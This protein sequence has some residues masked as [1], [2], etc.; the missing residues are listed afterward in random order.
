[1]IDIELQEEP[2]R[3]LESVCRKKGEEYRNAEPFPHA[4]LDDIVSDELLE[5]VDEEFPSPDSGQ[6]QLLEKPKKSKNK[7]ITGPREDVGPYTRYLFGELGSP[8]FLGFLE[9]LTGIRKLISDPYLHGGG[10]HQI[11]SGGFLELHSD[12]NWAKHLHMFRRINLI[13]Y[14]NKD[15]KEEYGGA[16]ELW[17]DKLEKSASYLPVWNRLVVQDVT[18]GALHGFPVPIRCPE[19]MTRKS[20][21]MCYYTAD[22][23]VSVQTGYDVCEPDFVHRTDRAHPLPHP[24]WRRVCPPVVHALLKRRRQTKSFSPLEF[25]TI[26]TRF[27]PPFLVQALHR[28]RR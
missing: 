20:I 22:L 24:L 12:F 9:E 3:D 28:I 4:Q 25:W 1:M 5:R 21:A 7:Q 23:P 26:V 8:R 17:D 19:E 27:L 13:L 11:R 14:L 2:F 6:W 16:L 18:A 15:W 10:L